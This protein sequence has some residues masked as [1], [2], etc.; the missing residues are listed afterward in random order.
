MSTKPTK[1]K[2]KTSSDATL[3]ARERLIPGPGGRL[4]EVKAGPKGTQLVP[5]N[6]DYERK[7]ILA[8]HGTKR[9]VVTLNEI[10]IPDLWHI[11]QRL[12][13]LSDEEERRDI[14]PDDEE[15]QNELTRRINAGETYGAR[16]KEQVLEVLFLAQDLKK[17]LA[18]DVE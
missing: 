12:Q 18:N 6:P 14:D 9:R 16:Q 5:A 17:N 4:F 3:L 7:V 15:L 8:A 13:A 11:A 10:E 2:K 1:R